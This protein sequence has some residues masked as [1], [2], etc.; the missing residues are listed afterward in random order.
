M[1][2]EMS[3]IAI[4][5]CF[6]LIHAHTKHKHWSFTIREGTILSLLNKLVLH[7]RLEI[8]YFRIWRI[9]G[10]V[11]KSGW[12]KKRVHI[13]GRE[14]RAHVLGV[15]DKVRFKPASSATE[16]SKNIRISLET[17]LY[18]ILSIQQIA[19]ALIRLREFAGWSAPLLFANPP[20]TGF[21]ASRPKLKYNQIP[22]PQQ[23]DCQ[24]RTDTKIYII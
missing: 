16:N 23:E 12:T 8:R 7:G 15:P 11:T 14:A 1:A 17:S 19:Q 24:G 5:Y 22:L 13:L 10:D 20:K 6:P 2:P 9:I 18:M 4:Y 3:K 21:L